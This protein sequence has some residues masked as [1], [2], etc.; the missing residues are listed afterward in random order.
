MLTIVTGPDAFLA[1][2]AVRRVRDQS[3]PTGLN[4]SVFDARA[5]GLDEIVGALRTPGFF[6]AGRVIVVHDLVAGSSRS[7]GDGPKSG[8]PKDGPNWPAIFSAVQPENCAIFVEM[9]LASI[10]AAVARQLPAGSDVV[11]SDPPRGAA[12][13]A[14]IKEKAAA[15]GSSIA[16]GEAR[17]LADLLSPGTWMAK[18]NNP[19]FD[20]P[21]ALELFANEIEKL[22]LAALPGLI[23]REHIRLLTMSAVADRRFPLLDALIAGDRVRVLRELG[24]SAGTEDEAVRLIVQIAQEAE[25]LAAADATRGRDPLEVGK[26]LGLSNPGRMAVISRALHQSRARPKRLLD[27]AL[28]VDRQLK[29]GELRRPEDQLHAEIDRFIAAISERGATDT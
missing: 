16:D 17:L 9:E 20:R 10:P 8:R 7:A 4:T 29:T 13:V 24:A 21:P 15:A 23:E 11:I 1:R 6:G 28:T 27:E 3:D 18:A 5:H 26:A 12:L 19:A 14:W 25:L 22:A 2:A